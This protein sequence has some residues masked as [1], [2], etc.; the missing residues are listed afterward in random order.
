M[1]VL[2]DC[3]SPEAIAVDRLVSTSLLSHHTV[4]G[5]PCMRFR[6]AAAAFAL[7]A[8]TVGCNS[9]GGSWLK[10]TRQRC[11]RV[12]DGMKADMSVLDSDDD[13]LDAFAP[14]DAKHLRAARADM[15]R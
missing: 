15:N 6:F 1:D 2:G 11:E 10:S 9:P 14:A 4:A 7:A 5:S 3:E 12:V 13:G 8:F